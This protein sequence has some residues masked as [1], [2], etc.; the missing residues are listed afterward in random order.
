MELALNLVWFCLVLLLATA[1]AV[2]S[3]RLRGTPGI[4]RAHIITGVIAL[5]LLAAI[6]L[7]VISL[8]DD[9]QAMATISEGDQAF[10]SAAHDSA[11]IACVQWSI[12]AVEQRNDPSHALSGRL[13]IAW[14]TP[15]PR[16]QFKRSPAAQ[17]PPPV[18]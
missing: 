1:F 16:S 3:W 7:P 12:L 4:H 14:N 9:L 8:T 18:A 2:R 11:A 10:R 13:R 5:V 17:R 6:A 15:I